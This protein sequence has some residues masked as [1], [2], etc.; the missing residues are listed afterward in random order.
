MSDQW[1]ALSHGQP[2][3]IG[4][5]LWCARYFVTAKLSVGTAIITATR[6]H[7]VHFGIAIPSRGQLGP[8]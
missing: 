1:L 7:F 5:A 3:E 8:P 6:S 2:G 4:Q